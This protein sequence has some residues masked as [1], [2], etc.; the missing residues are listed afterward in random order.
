MNNQPYIPPAFKKNAYNCP[1]CNAYATQL[2]GKMGVSVDNNFVRLSDF[3]ISRC[4]HC[5][6]FS[7]WKDSELIYPDTAKGMEPNPELP[8]EIQNIFK[9]A[10]S[11][12]GKSPGSASALLRICIRKLCAHLGET[13]ENIDK[14]IASLVDR[15]MN[16][17]IRD[18]LEIMRVIG[19]NSAPPGVI[20]FGDS[21]DSALQL[22]QL[23]N[24]IA[25]VMISHPRKIDEI[26]A[27]IPDG[28]QNLSVSRDKTT[29]KK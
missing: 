14:D 21:F 29:T 13:G 3:S 11:I 27:S 20:D 9:E 1:H 17:K 26:Y 19:E 23:I 22:C 15:G 7:V 2:W 18:S 4:K 12:I 6:S 10:Y 24:I 28:K 5:M 25:E 16:P 8:E